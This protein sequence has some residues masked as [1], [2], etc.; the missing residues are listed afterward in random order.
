MKVGLNKT[1][2]KH[3]SFEI[4]WVF[5]TD[6]KKAVTFALMLPFNTELGS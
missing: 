1:G 3:H 2:S 4:F 6:R 5:P